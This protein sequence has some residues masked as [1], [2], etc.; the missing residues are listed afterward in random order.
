MVKILEN[1]SIHRVGP[2]VAVWQG[3]QAWPVLGLEYIAEL[4]RS[5]SK[6]M[7]AGRQRQTPVGE[8]F[9]AAAHPVTGVVHLH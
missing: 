8:M 6:A 2:E 7:T 5:P 3:L 9:Q 4:L 1:V